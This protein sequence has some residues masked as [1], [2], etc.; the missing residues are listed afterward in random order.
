M[1]LRP[2]STNPDFHRMRQVSQQSVP[3]E[4]HYA[5][6]WTM[7]F[8]A[9]NSEP[10]KT[11]ANDSW[12]IYLQ[13]PLDFMISWATEVNC[14]MH[15]K[16]YH[17]MLFRPFTGT[18]ST[19]TACFKAHPNKFHGIITPTEANFKTHRRYHHL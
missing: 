5:R 4:Q 12:T 7:I 6:D 19:A 2:E 14:G 15:W 9:E 13:G 11:R 17:F 8:G 3:P 10:F 16:L 1:G 18:V